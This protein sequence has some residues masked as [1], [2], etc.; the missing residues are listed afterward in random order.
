MKK[1][2]L[3]SVFLFSSLLLLGQTEKKPLTHDDILK[4]ERITEQHISNNGKYIVY[5]QEP[6][7]G[8]PTLKITTPAGRELA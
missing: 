3:L 7:K 1:T 4:W 2:M 8:D 5:K 6:W